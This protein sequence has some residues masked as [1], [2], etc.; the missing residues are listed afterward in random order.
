MVSS[1]RW[2]IKRLLLKQLVSIIPPSLVFYLQ[3]WSPCRAL[4]DCNS[5]CSHAAFSSVLVPHWLPSSYPL[6]RIHLLPC[7]NPQCSAVSTLVFYIIFFLNHVYSSIMWLGL[8][9][10]KGEPVYA[11]VYIT[12]PKTLNRVLKCRTLLKGL[13]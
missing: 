6:T 8:R 4:D 5:T 11:Q 7:G 12:A 13:S 10:E 1:V 9:K 2:F 3:V